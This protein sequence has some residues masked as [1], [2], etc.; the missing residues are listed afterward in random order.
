MG[1]SGNSSPKISR[2][3]S[4]WSNNRWFHNDPTRS[5]FLWGPRAHTEATE[6]QILDFLARV[7]GTN[8]SSFQLSLRR[9]CKTKKRKPEPQVEP[10]LCLLP[11]PLHTLVRVYS[12]LLP[13]VKPGAESSFCLKRSVS[14]HRIEV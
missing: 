11:R 9:L 14:D 2:R 12:L 3:K 8:P 1:S 6:V 10:G 5:E 7:H 13:L 4:T